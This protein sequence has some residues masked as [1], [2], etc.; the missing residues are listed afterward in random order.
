MNYIKKIILGVSIIFSFF[1][2]N[3]QELTE[4]L[5]RHFN[6]GEFFLSR[7]EYKEALFNYLIIYE[8]GIK[9]ANLQYRIGLCYLNIDREKSKAIPYLKKA[10]DYTTLDY[11]EGSYKETQSPPEVYFYLGQ[12]YQVNYE[13]DNA[14][15]HYRNYISLISSEDLKASQYTR[16]QIEACKNAEDFMKNKTKYE[17]VKLE[18][19]INEQYNIIKPTVSSDDSIIVFISNLK[20][21]NGIF[22]SQKNENNEWETAQNIT[23]DLKWNGNLYPASLSSDGNKLLIAMHDNFVCNIYFSKYDKE[24]K[25]WSDYEELNSKINTKYWENHASMTK[26]GKTIYFSS[27][28]SMKNS[29]GEMDIYIITKKENGKWNNP[30]NLGNIINTKFNEDV[31]FITADGNTLFFCSQ[32]HKS[33]GGYDIFFTT[34]KGENNWTPPKNIGYPINSPDD[35][36]YFCPTKNGK[37]GYFERLNKEDN[38][39][40]LYKVILKE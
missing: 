7:G 36:K 27:N 1:T 17:I 39:K 23:P 4:N 14:I 33:M 9:N 10:S 15:K 6:D 40:D 32:G 20:F 38:E 30:E 35:D 21:Y 8:K 18:D 31:P 3:G 34:K 16:L 28:A 29:H 25:K 26:D 11:H 2:I 37:Y 19:K 12:A 5:K 22:M 24:Q 13:F